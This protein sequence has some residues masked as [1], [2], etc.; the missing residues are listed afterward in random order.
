[1]LFRCCVRQTPFVKSRLADYAFLENS[2]YG[3]IGHQVYRYFR[4]YPTDQLSTRMM[5]SS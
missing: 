4:T 1:M 2:L 3:L 5:V